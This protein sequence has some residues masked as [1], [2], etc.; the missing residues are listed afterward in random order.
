MRSAPIGVAVATPYLPELESLRGVAIALVVLFHLDA[1]LDALRIFFDASQGTMVSPLFAFIRAGSSG[2]SL[3]FILSAFLLSLPFLTHAAGGK[4]VSVRRYAG[5][6]ALRIL[7]LYWCAVAAAA[8]LSASSATDVLRGLPYLVFLNGIAD[9]TTPLPPYSNVWW[10]LATEAQF[11][12]LL[13]LLPLAL[14]T[15]RRRVAGAIGLAAIIAAYAAFLTG[16]LHVRSILGQMAL[17]YSVLGRAPMFLAGIAAAWLYL[18][19]GERLRLRLAR[20]GLLRRGGADLLLLAALVGLG[21]LLRWVTSI[22]TEV[23]ELP[24]YQIWHVAETVLWTTV[25]LLLLL[26]PLRLKP[27]LSNPL[28]DRLGVLSYSLY[29]VHVPMI[30]YGLRLLRRAW[31]A[32][33]GWGPSGIAAAL[34]ICLAC[35]ALSELTYRAIE[36]PFLARKE[37]LRT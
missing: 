13:P 15:P 5:R 29:I 21:Y 36:R 11:Y 25:V 33:S 22:G 10:S 7:P 27:L 18:H 23:A 24:R 9:L 35:V 12:L 26:A 17:G 16:G 31:P 34:A 20:N 30:V 14:G 8:V 6:R 19:H 37:H 2:V 1:H 4:Q 3:F 28:L 32:L